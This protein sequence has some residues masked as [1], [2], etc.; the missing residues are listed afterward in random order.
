MLFHQYYIPLYAADRSS[1]AGFLSQIF[2]ITFKLLRSLVNAL[3]FFT[4]FF[5]YHKR[6]MRSFLNN[7]LLPVKEQGSNSFLEVILMTSWM[8]LCQRYVLHEM[9][10][11]VFLKTLLLLHSH[12]QC[13]CTRCQSKTS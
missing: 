8:V 3:N 4:K 5:N 11:Y 6:A 10:I 1:Q 13:S 7:F 2:C 12:P 9:Y